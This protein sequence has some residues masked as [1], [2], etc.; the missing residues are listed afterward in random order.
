MPNIVRRCA[1]STSPRQN[2]SSAALASAFSSSEGGVTLS[3]RK[4]EKYTKLSPA[5]LEANHAEKVIDN[6]N[7]LISMQRFK[8]VENA[9]VLF[10]AMEARAWAKET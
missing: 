1:S 7:P 5:L 8:H 2:A 6:A 9:V 4:P 3:A 10:A